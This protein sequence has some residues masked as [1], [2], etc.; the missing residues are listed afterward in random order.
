M[1]IKVNGNAHTLAGKM[2]VAALTES[3]G[4][5]ATQIAIERNRE[6]VP[7]SQWGEVMLG[8]A[9]EVEIVRFIGGG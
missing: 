3:L 5:S 9:D 8:E 1:Q 2:S 4:L 7:R 6:I